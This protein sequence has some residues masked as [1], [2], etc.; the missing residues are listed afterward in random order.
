MNAQALAAL[1]LICPSCRQ[2]GVEA[3]LQV[4]P[5]HGSDASHAVD[6][7]FFDCPRGCRYPIIAGIPII[8]R[9]MA[10]WWQQS[11]HH[12]SA[13]TSEPPEMVDYFAYLAHAHPERLAE[14]ALLSTYMD[15]HYGHP[16]PPAS[17]PDSA[18]YW[19][20]ITTL[21]ERTTAGG[22]AL[23]L[24][25]GVG[26][27]SFELARW[28]QQVIGLDLNFQLVAAA[29]CIQRTQQLDY[30]RRLRGQQFTRVTQPWS[31]PS[32]VLFLVADALDPP[33]AAASFDTVAALNLLDNVNVPLVLLSQ[34]DALLRSGGT[35]LLASPYEW[36]SD[37]SEVSQWLENADQ[38]AAMT[39]RQ[40]LSAQLIPQLPL[41]YQITAELAELPW[42]LRQHQR[43]WQWFTVHSLAARKG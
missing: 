10:D 33:F 23:D 14:R 3:R 16:T 11:R 18:E 7:G 26:R 37:I 41:N 22:L 30:E 5:L 6:N 43:F 12:L 34:M 19:Q 21:A 1:A 28:H 36:R 13:M 17:W 38:D 8:L 42:V 39:L 4:R 2:Q 29:A 9:D 32:N 20:H 27:L 24:G 31:A 15:A 35:L 25:C 40:I